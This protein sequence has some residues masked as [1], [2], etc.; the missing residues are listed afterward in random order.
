MRNWI[1]NVN[2]DLGFQLK[3]LEVLSGLDEKEKDC[4]LI[5]DIMAI[6]QQIAWS[7]EKHKYI[8]FCDYG[9]SVSLENNDV[10]AMEAL[11]FLLVSLKGAWKWPIAYFLV[12]KVS[13]TILWQL[14]RN[15][16]TLCCE[17]TST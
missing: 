16:L 4:C 7:G 8:G 5:F 12:N 2:I 6:K 14:L 15:A 11:V 13:S 9:N 17:Y 10:E 1:S 3:V